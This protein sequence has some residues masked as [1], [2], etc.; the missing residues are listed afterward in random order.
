MPNLLHKVTEVP[1]D[2]AKFVTQDNNN[3]LWQK[4]IY[5]A[6]VNLDKAKFIVLSGRTSPGQSH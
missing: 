5:V 6:A 2:N 4:S 3:C 1:S